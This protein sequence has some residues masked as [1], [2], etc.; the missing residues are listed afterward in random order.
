AGR[1]VRLA[2]YPAHLHQGRITRESVL[3]EEGLEG[4]ASLAMPEFHAAHVE[5]DAVERGRVGVGGHEGELRRWID[6]ATNEPGA[7]GAVNVGVAASDAAHRLSGSFRQL[8]G[9]QSGEG[10]R[11]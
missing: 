6:E 4:T 11:R 8:P 3:L 1:H 7:A 10:C 5:H 9:Y 2:Q